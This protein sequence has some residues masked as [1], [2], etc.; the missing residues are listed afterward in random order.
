MH[1]VVCNYSSINVIYIL[2]IKCGK[3]LN[4]DYLKDVGKSI[5]QNSTPI[6]NFFFKLANEEQME[7]SFIWYRSLY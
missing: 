4:Y 3:I 5:Y 6:H 7:M 2:K 1:F